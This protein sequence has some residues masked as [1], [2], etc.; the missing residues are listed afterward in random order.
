MPSPEVLRAL[1]PGVARRGELVGIGSAA[2]C[3]DAV[4]TTPAAGGL[5]RLQCLKL[6]RIVSSETG[7]CKSMHCNY[8]VRIFLNIHMRVSV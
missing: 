5:V 4:Y 3:G 8:S 7:M 6:T 1:T 2:R